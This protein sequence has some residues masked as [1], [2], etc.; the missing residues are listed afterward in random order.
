MFSFC[1]PSVET[2]FLSGSNLGPRDRGW[3]QLSN[4]YMEL[5]FSVFY[6][7][8]STFPRAFKEFFSVDEKPG[9]KHPDDDHITKSATVLEILPRKHARSDRYIQ[10]PIA[11]LA[12]EESGQE[13][14]EPSQTNEPSLSF[15]INESPAIPSETPLSSPD[16]LKAQE[17]NPEKTHTCQECNKTFNRA[18]NLRAHMKTH[19][20]HKPYKCDFCG[21][22]FHQKID[23]RIHHY[24]HTGEKPHKCTKC[25]R[26]FKQLTHLNYHMRTH[27]DTHMYHCS[28][29][30]KGFNQKGNL[31]AHI[32]GH[33][34][35]RPFK[36]EI[37]SKGFTLRSTLNT[38]VRT[39]ASKKPFVCE[40]CNKA[41]YQKNA[42]KMHHI[43]SHPI[44]NGKSIL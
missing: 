2:V 10:K 25:G 6:S 5:A 4:Y 38:H 29:C 44:V 19:S 9:I 26:G 3:P 37:C 15:Q 33:T 16:E 8:V 32:Y 34:G 23:K 22:G 42:L 43:A 17:S 12:S 31:Q 39:H 27:S 28:Y 13:G 41:F 7:E 14:G 30:G 24:I 11:Q 36:C 1:S 18:S 20:D 35:Q 21:K 40:H